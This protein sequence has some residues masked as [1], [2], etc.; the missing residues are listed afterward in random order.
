[1]KKKSDPR[2]W[3]EV[4]YAGGVGTVKG[5]VPMVIETCFLC[6]RGAFKVP[7]GMS[8]LVVCKACRE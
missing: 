6:E 7:G 1:V 5:P 3:N 2:F 8:L 4:R